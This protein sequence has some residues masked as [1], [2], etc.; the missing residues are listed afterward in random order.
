MVFRRCSLIGRDFGGG[1]PL[2]GTVGAALAG[3]SSTVANGK[4]RSRHS[5]DP[6]LEVM[7]ATTVKVSHAY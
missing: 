7:L 3:P 2:T 5:K 6:T 4:A 1:S